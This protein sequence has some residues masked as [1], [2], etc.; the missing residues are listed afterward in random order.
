[1]SSNSHQRPRCEN[2]SFA[3]QGLDDHVEAFVEPCVGLVH[4]HPKAG[5]LVIA[6][7]AADPEIEPAA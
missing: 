2:G 7:A 4:R 3:V 6:V 5:E 1:M